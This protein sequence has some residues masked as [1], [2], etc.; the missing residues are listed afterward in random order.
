MQD[1]ISQLGYTGA[2]KDAVTGGYPLGNGYR[3]YL[4]SLLR[5][6]AP[7]S[8]S[9]FGRGG[10]NPYTYCAGDPINKSDPSGHMNSSEEDAIIERFIRDTATTDS[11]ATGHAA[12]A[13]TENT[14]GPSTSAAARRADAADATGTSHA[15]S[16]S[17]NAA[18]GAGIPGPSS[19]PA[20]AAASNRPDLQV[21][22]DRAKHTITTDYP[23]SVAR[24]QHIY[25]HAV[26]PSLQDLHNPLIL[27]NF[28]KALME[29]QLAAEYELESHRL[30]RWVSANVSTD[31]RDEDDLARSL[32][33]PG[34][35]YRVGRLWLPHAR[36]HTSFG[37]QAPPTSFHFKWLLGEEYINPAAPSAFA[38]PF[39]DTAP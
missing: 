29:T 5:F 23:G 30:S 28:Q 3:T 4:P 24:L 36:P 34:D 35:W 18:H 37:G 12:A 31:F 19:A 38:P 20:G 9:P 32:H 16:A 33:H 6:C 26:I 7:D 22:W 27:Q 39:D 8:W 11:I 21:M 15:A 14:A 1:S 2:Y 13:G 17:S 25:P 10:V